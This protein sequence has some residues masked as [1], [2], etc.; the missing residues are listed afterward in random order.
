MG[1]WQDFTQKVRDFF[2]QIT[3]EPVFL[4]FSFNLGFYI[5]VAKNLYIDKVCKVNLNFTEEICDNIQEHKEEQ[6][7]VQ[8]YVSSLQAYN[9]V[10]QAIF[11]CIFALFAGPWSDRHGRRALIICAVFGYILCNAVFIINTYYFYEL[12]A[13]YLLFECIQGKFF[14]RILKWVYANIFDRFQ[15]WLEEAQP[16]SWP[17]THT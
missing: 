16:F 13:E 17:H 1:C 10:I 12:K 3:I 2:S 7:Q 9:S 15:I 6:I 4:L 8:Q 5:I 14:L 11:P